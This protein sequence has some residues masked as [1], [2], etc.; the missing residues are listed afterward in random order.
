MNQIPLAVIALTALATSAFAA[1]PQEPAAVGHQARAVPGEAMEVVVRPNSYWTDPARK[2]EHTRRE[3]YWSPT[4]L[5]RGS[6]AI[7]WAPYEFWIDGQTSNCG[8]DTFDLVKVEG[9]WR[10]ANAMW[11]V[12][13]AACD[14]LRPR[15]ET[16]IRPKD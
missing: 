9:A 12:E 11:T 3:R 10:V 16:E 4:V 8:V 13:P 14:E 15:D 2:D 1:T 5:V 7:E 6:I